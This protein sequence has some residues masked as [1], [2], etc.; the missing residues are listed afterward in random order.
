MRTED[1]IDRLSAEAAPVR[2]VEAGLAPWLL[3]ALA[4]TA[5]LM[6]LG[7][8][9]RVG[10]GAAMATPGPLLKT[11]LPALAAVAGLAGALRLA[12]P[13]AR[14]GGVTR[15]L[16]GLGVAALALLALAALRTP[17]AAWGAALRGDTLVACLLS[18]PALAVLPT[19]GLLLG[20]RRGASAAPARSG[21]L[22]GLAGGGMAAALY[23][24]H[25]PEDHPFFFVTWYGTGVLLATL[26]G[27]WL[28]RRILSW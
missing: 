2:S 9:P 25:C 20:L 26:A 19:A 21:A 3:G 7:W 10:L 24:L 28:G 13:E 4:A 16:A 17:A 22:A 27:A 6:L 18:I 5:A 12:R 8:G 15:A 23:A 14:A 1:L 11:L